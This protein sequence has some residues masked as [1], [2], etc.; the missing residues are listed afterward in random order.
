MRLQGQAEGKCRGFRPG[1]KLG[2]WEVGTT[3]AYIDNGALA[4]MFQPSPKSAFNLIF[5]SN[6]FTR[7]NWRSC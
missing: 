7:F 2:A 3:E 5:K 6:A 4:P 1:S